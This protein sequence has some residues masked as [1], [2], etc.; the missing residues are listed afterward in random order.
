MVGK[1]CAMVLID[2][3]AEST[4][5]ETREK[6]CGLRKDRSFVYQ[7]LVT[8][9]LCEKS[10]EK[11]RVVYKTFMDAKKAHDCLNREALWLILKV[12]GRV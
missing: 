2:R 5:M 8:G 9:Q 6:Q 7:N 10:K 11:Q 3:V 1:V 12:Y 4:E